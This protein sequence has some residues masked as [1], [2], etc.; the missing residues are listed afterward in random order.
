MEIVL[1]RFA[2]LV[3]SMVVGIA[4]IAWWSS[5][6]GVSATTALPSA[7]RAEHPA[8][9]PE[10]LLSPEDLPAAR[11]SGRANVPDERSAKSDQGRAKWEWSVPVRGIRS[12]GFPKAVLLTA[13]NGVS[14]APQPG[15]RFT[16]ASESLVRQQLTQ[17]A[18]NPAALSGARICRGFK[19]SSSSL[20]PL[21]RV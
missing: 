12:S 9:P 8:E 20:E 6:S 16:W 2:P 11:R 3:A 15:T 7:H 4:L 13:I 10:D 1:R 19:A 18:F 21:P 5:R 17:D 14:G